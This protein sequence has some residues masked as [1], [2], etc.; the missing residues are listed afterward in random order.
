MEKNFHF[1][2]WVFEK[3]LPGI[4]NDYKFG[5]KIKKKIFSG[6]SKYQK[7]EVFDTYRF[8]KIL[9]LDGIFQLS[10]RDEFIYHEMI[11][12]L[13]LFCHPNPQKVLII[14]GGDGGILREVLKHPIKKVYLVEIDERVVEVS[15]KYL[16]FISK[17]AFRDKR[18]K[19]CIEDGKK[20]IK[21][22]RNFFDV[23]ILDLTDPSG[24]SRLLFTKRSYQ[25]VYQSLKKGGIMVTQSGNWFY[26]FPEIKKVF[27]NLKKIFPFVK[28][29]RVTIP[30]YQGAEFSLTLGSKKVNLDKIDLKKLKERYKKL[31]LKTKYYSPE[32]HFASSVLPKYL[33]Y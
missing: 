22:Y 6:K 7:I 33:K 23:I 13:P 25:S 5:V 15:Q 28:I 14:G 3:E 16:P 20:F 19:I 2:N 9:A 18:V 12:H 27:K 31:N 17:G 30:I 8:G 4:K 10:E 29:H 32:I 1:K 21:K 24:P 11:S 26:Q